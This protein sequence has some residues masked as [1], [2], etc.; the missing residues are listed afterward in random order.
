MSGYL[1][2][3]LFFRRMGSC[4]RWLELEYEIGL[5][6]NLLAAAYN[7]FLQLLWNP[8]KGPRLRSFRYHAS[9][10]THQLLH[11]MGQAVKRAGYPLGNVVGKN[12]YMIF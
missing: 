2:L 10:L 9:W 12:L 1:G 6:Q 5:Q 4:A 8:I 7:S 3:C 11:D